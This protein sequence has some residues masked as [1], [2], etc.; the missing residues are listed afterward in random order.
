MN[1]AIAGH[2]AIGFA[3]LI[4]AGWIVAVRDAVSL[5]GPLDLAVLRYAT[6]A[7]LLAPVWLRLGP[8]PRGV[9]RLR[10]AIMTLGWGAPFALVAAQGLRDAPVTLF[11]ALVPGMMPLWLAALAAGFLG[12]RPSRG[13]LAGL[14]L[15]AAAGLTALWAAPPGALAGA[16]W[17]VAASVAWAAY[18]LAFRGSGLT[19]I[20][21]TAVVS[22]WSALA[23]APAALWFGL[24][25]SDL[26]PAQLA[27]Q[28]L[29]QGVLAGVAAVAAFAAAVRMLGAQRAAGFTAMVP[30][31]ATLG[32]WL[33]LAETPGPAQ[34][35]SVA[36]VVAGV[37]LVNRVPGRF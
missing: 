17:L 37:A 31:I 15:V 6:P 11:V 26:T 36:M 27:G 10:I 22:F 7:L 35:A 25:L 4:W 1:P 29:A 23:L 18:T 21:A 5:L 8:L 13:A 2:A 14:V 12:L 28:T 30:V 20:Q 34:L 3:V 33:W 9:S 32:G 24:R 16:P 19:A